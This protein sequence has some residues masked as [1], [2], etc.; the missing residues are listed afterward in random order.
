[1]TR[2][3]GGP[4]GYGHVQD[5]SDHGRHPVT[6]L[7]GARGRIAMSDTP[8]SADLRPFEA[9]RMDQSITSACTAHAVSN[10]LF[11]VSG[12]QRLGIVPWVP[13][14]AGIYGATRILARAAARAKGD[15]SAFAPLLDT[16][17][18]PL[19]VARAISTIG[20]RPRAILDPDDRGSDIDPGTI[21]DEPRFGELEAEAKTL[22]LGEYFL[23]ET[24]PDF[25]AQF[26]ATLAAGFP[27]CVGIFADTAFENWDPSKGPL[28]A[29]N[30]GDPQGGGHYILATYYRTNADGSTVIGGPNSWGRAWGID[31]RW[32]GNGAFLANTNN[33]IALTC[34]AA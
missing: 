12:A 10:G 23:D 15:A 34:R 31:G 30:Y 11:T 3:F 14:Q 4:S 22:I 18:M 32:E 21:N 33:L 27:V 5:P 9:P 8:T 19:D 16:G 20:V 17:A 6:A 25:V 29:P 24:A 13:S 1:M 7:L 28:G 2:R 26:R